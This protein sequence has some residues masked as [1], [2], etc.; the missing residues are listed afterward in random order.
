MRKG[1]ILIMAI[2][3]A[4]CVSAVSDGLDTAPEWFQ[5]RQEELKGSN[6]PSLEAAVKLK[7]ASDDSPWDKIKSDLDVAVRDLK[8]GDTGPVTITAEEMRA[9]AAQQ[10]ALVAK[11]EDPY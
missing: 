6:Y 10:Q 5:K 1:M 4:G 2:S 9:W 8:A 7:E 11:G 3:C